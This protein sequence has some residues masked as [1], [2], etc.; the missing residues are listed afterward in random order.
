MTSQR[1]F[2]PIIPAGAAAFV[3]IALGI[4]LR[5]PLWPVVVGALVCCA[6]GALG[7]LAINR[8]PPDPVFLP[9]APQ[10]APVIQTQ[11]DQVQAINLP[12]AEPDY[13]FILDVTVYWRSIGTAADAQQHFR[14][15]AR[16]IDS[17]IERAAQVAANVPPS[18]AIRLQ[19]RLN[20]VLGIV[21]PDRT[22]LVEAW[23]DQVR[24]SLSDADVGRLHE[25]AT[26]R[27]N[28]ELWEHQRRFECDRR[29]YLTDDVLRSTGSALVWWLSRNDKEVDQAVALIGTM[30]QLSAAARDEE[31]SQVFPGSGSDGAAQP[32]VLGLAGP[33]EPIDVF[34]E[35]VDSLDLARGQRLLLV[36]HI[37]NGL[38]HSGD[39]RDKAMA[40]EIRRRF[41]LIT[42]DPDGQPD[43]PSSG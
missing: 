43:D 41:D 20:D 16:G 37:A 3:L 12:S 26:I 34:I 6:A 13:E 9:P 7:Y 35:W 18:M 32:L 24:I 19:H 2:G 11:R 4:S 1:K 22:G 15:G 31:I 38:E 36:E 5:W 39:P 30:T 33:R 21:Q 10:P 29:A 25:M 27:K 28:K 40:Y 8:R 42:D 14:P 17:I 23:A